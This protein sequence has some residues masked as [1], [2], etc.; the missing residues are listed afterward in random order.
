MSAISRQK[1][2]DCSHTGV[3]PILLDYNGT[4]V[5][6]PYPAPPKLFPGSSASA[7]LVWTAP[8]RTWGDEGQEASALE[9]VEELPALQAPAGTNTKQE[10]GIS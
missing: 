2:N 9:E 5:S 4:G 10:R 8:R 6:S 3:G 7:A 1:G